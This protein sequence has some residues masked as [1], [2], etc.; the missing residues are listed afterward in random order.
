MHCRLVN[1]VY[2]IIHYYVHLASPQTLHLCAL[3]SSWSL[4]LSAALVFSL[5]WISDFLLAHLEV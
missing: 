1:L 5:P 3:L 4:F 2:S